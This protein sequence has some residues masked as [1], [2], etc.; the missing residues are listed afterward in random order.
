MK[1]DMNSTGD[2]RRRRSTTNMGNVAEKGEQL[3]QGTDESIS[4][5]GSTKRHDFC[6]NFNSMV[7]NQSTQW[8]VDFTKKFRGAVKTPRQ[9]FC[10]TIS[11]K[12][13]RREKKSQC[14]KEDMT[15]TAPIN[16]WQVGKPNLG[17][18]LMGRR[19]ELKV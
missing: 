8:E 19:G 10:S 2:R 18:P 1:R 4:T 9:R 17:N 6:G 16:N 14:F 11:R 12:E 7:T 15:N 13:N 5:C 3:D